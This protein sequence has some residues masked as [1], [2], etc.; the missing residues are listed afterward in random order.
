LWIVI[1][2]LWFITLAYFGFI[3]ETLIKTFYPI[4]QK[5]FMCIFI[6]K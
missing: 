1:F 5:Y 3:F 2:P 6:V 4:F